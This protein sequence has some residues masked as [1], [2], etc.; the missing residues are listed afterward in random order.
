MFPG[1][2]ERYAIN[3]SAKYH[4]ETDTVD[5]SIEDSGIGISVKEFQE[6]ILKTGSSWK[7]RQNYKKNLK[8]CRNG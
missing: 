3:I 4:E 1:I 6:H 5:F 7:N 2:F 8:V